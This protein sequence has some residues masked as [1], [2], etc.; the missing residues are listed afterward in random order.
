[1]NAR[2]EDAYRRARDARL[3]EL[4]AARSYRRNQVLAAVLGAVAL[5]AAA[6]GLS[7][8]VLAAAALVAGALVGLGGHA[9]WIRRQ[10]AQAGD[11]ARMELWAGDR[12]FRYERSIEPR[13]TVAF[14][15]NREDPEAEDCFFGPMAGGQ[16]LLYNFAYI[17]WETRTVSDGQG[18][19]RTVRERETH[20]YT[21]LE[22]AR[23]LPIERLSVERRTTGFMRGF[24]DG[25][26]S[27]LTSE[28]AVKL[29]SEEFDRGF[30]VEVPDGCDDLVVRR[31]FEPAVIVAFIDG[32]L[33][34]TDFQYENGTFVLWQDGHV[35][36]D[37]LDRLDALIAE[38]TPLIDLLARSGARIRQPAG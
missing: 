37:E 1:M 9:A 15:R 38:A 14:L 26:G 4:R 32:R 21:V 33:P 23:P 30:H 13:D 27:A 29:E 3:A 25:V 11:R 6:L 16:G 22:V 34:R 17:T 35:D 18:G 36:N 19:T 5:A 2:Y 7:G 24:T 20:R 31:I 8:L 12:G 10:A 28:R